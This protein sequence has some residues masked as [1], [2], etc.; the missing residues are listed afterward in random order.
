MSSLAEKA[1]AFTLTA[2]STAELIAESQRRLK[3]RRAAQA[4]SMEHR[5]ALAAARH[6]QRRFTGAALT[7]FGNNL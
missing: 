2:Q 1:A 5:L 7:N 6:D 4:E 3:A